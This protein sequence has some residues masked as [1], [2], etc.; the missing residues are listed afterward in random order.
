MAKKSKSV[1][2]TDEVL[3]QAFDSPLAQNVKFKKELEEVQLYYEH[4]DGF[5]VTD[6]NSDYGQTWKIDEDKL[7]Y[8]P[9][10]EIRNLIRQL[11][12]KQSRFMMSQEP[13]LVFNAVVEGRE[14][15]AE[16]K[17]ILFDSILRQAN[18]WP[19]AASALT[20]ATVGKRVLMTVLGNEGESVDVRFYPMP[21]FS[22][23][24]DPKDSSKLLVVD[25]V[26]QDE[27]TRGMDK[28]AQ[29]W[30]HY[31]YEM[32]AGDSESGITSA[33]EDKEEECWLTYVL[34]DGESN[35]IYITE[36][37][38]TTIKESSAKLVDI[39]DNLGNK[40]Q[41]P[42]ALMESA[43]TGLSQIPARV[44]LN[45]PLTNDVY[46]NSDVKDLITIADN[47]NRTISD[48]RDAL[49]FRM[50]E[51]P[52]II[53]GST[54]SLQGMKIAPNAV[55]DLKTDTSTSI[56][57]GGGSKQA[58]VTSISSNFNFLPAVQYYLD[59]AK[60]SMYEL[61]DQPLPEKVQS[62]PS[63]IAMQFLFYD[64]MSRCDSKWVEWDSAIEWLVSMIEEILEKVSV[65][66]EPLP[67]D[68]KSSWQEIT[69]LTINHNY[70]L[71]ADEQAKR[72]TA[73]QEV[74]T[75]VRS[76]QS[77][78]EEFS[79][80]ENAEDEW[81]RILEEAAQL[82]ELSSGAM[83]QLAENESQLE[84]TENEQTE[85]DETDAPEGTEEE[86]ESEPS[87]AGESGAESPEAEL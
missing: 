63:G 74:Q 40:I 48:L 43:P 54:K 34:T 15:Q 29:L 46:G 41:V 57:A 55:I 4:F 1:S 22:Y 14:K 28:E 82:E 37:G 10:R 35:Q 77:Y 81:S 18:F 75:S 23:T 49:R 61:M 9:T 50:F 80:N 27:R 20:D 45:E 71:P 56:G 13:E 51:Q 52:V 39:E 38:G 8:K 67:E 78:I 65:A 11:V 2:H 19:K 87:G 84:D 26:Y 72:Q 85:E 25:I 12:K 32:K 36:D 86:S 62:A 58:S 47:M 16:Q 7:D 21:Q 30:H 42:L 83:L 76:H 33:L 70:P 79:R 69:T 6:M 59:E 60:R 66:I 3:S 31:R 24:V 44:I 17:R 73:M 68:L 53:D 5:D 64:L